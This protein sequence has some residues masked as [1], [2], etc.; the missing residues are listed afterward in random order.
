[1]QT[2]DDVRIR[3][4]TWSDG[5]RGTVLLLP[6][7]GEFI[8]KYGSVIGQLTQR[9][10]ACVVLDW[11]THGLSDRWP[12]DPAMGHVAS[13]DD[14]RKDLDAVMDHPLVQALPQNIVM[15]AHSMGGCVGLR[16][17][18]D[19]L[20]PKA[21]IFTS[22][23]WEL[24][25]APVLKP[26]LKILL[27]FTIF[28][29]FRARYSPGGG[30][31]PYVQNQPFEDNVLTGNPVAYA[32]FQDRMIRLP[33][34]RTGGPSLN[35]LA[36]ANREMKALRKLGLTE[37]PSLCVTG[38]QEDIIVTSVVSDLVARTKNA[39]LLHLED[40]RHE[41]FFETEAIQTKVWSAIDRF[42]D[43]IL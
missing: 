8:E 33:E 2:S 34:L 20:T 21:A 22:P 4:A 43:P 6:G 28:K 11:R 36:S 25:V 17:L 29:P 1:M 27:F 19:H 39:E 7:R 5:N 23:M 3:F 12:A 40:A 18:H 41:P 38:G 10:F 24:D 31:D 15:V 13:F 16:A 37:V 14:Y 35:W 9:G 30:P 42:L 32:A 26:L